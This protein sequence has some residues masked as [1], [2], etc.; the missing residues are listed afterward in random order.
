MM[1]ARMGR[2]P[3]KTAAAHPTPSRYQME[4]VLL[5]AVPFSYS[6]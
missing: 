3:Y 5:F 1:S 2:K 6:T 4:G